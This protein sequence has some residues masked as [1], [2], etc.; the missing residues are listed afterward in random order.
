MVHWREPQNIN[1]RKIVDNNKYKEISF[2]RKKT[3]I[4]RCRYTHDWKLHR[5]HRSSRWRVLCRRLLI[6]YD[7]TIMYPSNCTNTKHQTVQQGVANLNVIQRLQRV[8][9]SQQCGRTRN[10]PV[11]QKPPRYI[12]VFYPYEPGKR[13]RGIANPKKQKINV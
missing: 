1:Q 10:L 2:R 12:H 6:Y 3:P 9:N 7:T 13:N 4:P 5:Q 11:I 8:E